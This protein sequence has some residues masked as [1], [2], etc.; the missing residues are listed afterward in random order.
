MKDG[1]LKYVVKGAVGAALVATPAFGG[2][3]ASG[4]AKAM[5][6]TIAHAPNAL[7][8]AVGCT[9][10]GAV[11]VGVMALVGGKKAM[12]RAIP[13]AIA[14]VA[15]GTLLPIVDSGIDSLVRNAIGGSASASSAGASSAPAAAPGG[16][17]MRLLSST[18]GGIGN[19]GMS[20]SGVP[21]GI[22]KAGGSNF[23][24]VSGGVLI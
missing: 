22:S 2:Q 14:G 19:S 21:G 13:L 3:L 8:D 15:L 12:G 23:N 7:V 6:S 5:S 17:G 18:P 1:F 10:V 24:S 16:M 9:A 20:N 11:E 4:I